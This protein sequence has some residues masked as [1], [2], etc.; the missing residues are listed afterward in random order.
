MRCREDMVADG[1]GQGRN[2]DGC[3]AGTMFATRLPEMP[4]TDVVRSETPVKRELG[5]AHRVQQQLMPSVRRLN[6]LDVAISFQPHGQVGGDYIDVVPMPDGRTLLLIADV[7]GKGLAGAMVAS[8]LH[9]LV[10]TCTAFGLNL[11]ELVATLNVYLCRFLP[12]GW[13]VTLDAVVIETG[14]GETEA[15][16][17][18]HP[19]TM[20]LDRSGKLRRL[21]AADT[22]PLGITRLT[23]ETRSDR[24]T[25]GETLAMF[26][27][28]LIELTSERGQTLGIDGLASCLGSV[29]ESA[30]ESSAREV[31]VQ[32]NTRLDSF[33]GSVPPSDDRTLLVAR[34]A[35]DAQFVVLLAEGMGWMP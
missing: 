33:R 27:D 7:C 1:R 4:R 2:G 11:A 31:V 26:T 24:I 15:I 10:H 25:A 3:S 30:V 21:Q 8:G 13:F 6:G 14:T 12:E 23:A 17:A 9:S 20:V 22:L 34:R 18:G 19:P 29:D 5:R 35:E 16:N 28:G 32:L